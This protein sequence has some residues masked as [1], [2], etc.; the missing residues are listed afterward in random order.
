MVNTADDRTP[1]GDQLLNTVT[2]SELEQR[3]ASDQLTT[4]CLGAIVIARL[5]NTA[6]SAAV[7]HD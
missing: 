6:D 7:S 5:S 2:P 4:N 1:D 3:K